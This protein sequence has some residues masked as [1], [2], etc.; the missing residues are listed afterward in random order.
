MTTYRPFSSVLLLCTLLVVCGESTAQNTASSDADLSGLTLSAGTLVPAFARDSLAYTAT[1]ANSIDSLTIM[2]TSN[3]NGATI[4]V[5]GTSVSSGNASSAIPLSVGENTITIVVAAED[6]KMTKTYTVTVER[7]VNI[8][9]A[10]LRAA[11]EGALKKS[12]GAIITPSEMATLTHLDARR[13]SDMTGLEYATSLT[14]LRLIF[15]N[16]SDISALSGLTRLTDL[17]LESSH[18]SD[19][20]ALSGL[21]RLERLYLGV[22][23]ISDISAL[24]GLT[25]LTNLNLSGN[26]ISDISALSGL[27]SLGSLGLIDT[28]LS[29]ISALSGLTS[30]GS[31]WLHGNNLSDI[32]ALS[33]LTSLIGLWLGG[34]PLNYPSLATHIPALQSRGVNVRYDTRTL[35]SLVKISGDAQTG[36][37]GSRLSDPFIVEVRDQNDVAF[38]GVP[39]TFSVTAGGG[40]LSTTTDTTDANG[41]ASTRLTLGAVGANTV[42][43]II[44]VADIDKSVTFTV[45]AAQVGTVVRGVNI[46]DADLR[47]AIERALK[48]S[49]GA[50]IAPS[51]MPTLTRLSAR[52]QNIRFC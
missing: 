20:S 45:T 35:T 44:D 32:S 8:P 18:I 2:P 11:I 1:V 40:S 29:D 37:A 7:G 38:A 36:T 22:N 42:K 5:N 12:S 47:G 24:S 26:R 51:E 49:S 25:R 17:N 27:T 23:R 50:I 41:R 10:T 33:G 15:T 16:I 3:H 52:E 14:W 28:N 13:V 4:T 39:V 48:K 9:D 46:P 34:N 30:L 19:I 6:G 21:T 31:L 43:A